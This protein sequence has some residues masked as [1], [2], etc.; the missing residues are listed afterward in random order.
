MK[1]LATTGPTPALLAT[2]AEGATMRW[3][4]G[5][6]TCAQAAP[7][8]TPRGPASTDGA[9]RGRLHQQ[10]VAAT[11]D[12]HRHHHARRHRLHQH[13]GLRPLNREPAVCAIV[14]FLHR[15]QRTKTIQTTSATTRQM[16]RKR[17]LGY[18]AGRL[19]QLRYG[20]RLLY[21]HRVEGVSKKSVERYRLQ[22]ILQ[23]I[24]DE[25]DRLRWT[26]FHHG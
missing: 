15:L 18:A 6:E 12:T 25:I 14:H 22:T 8:R 16:D 4:V 23:A 21:T 13:D 11:R 10:P 9:S 24:S 5:G 17:V 2:T 3:A 19:V 26:P 7:A 20:E 1:R